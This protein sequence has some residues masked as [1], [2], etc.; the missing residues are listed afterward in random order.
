MYREYIHPPLSFFIP[1]P[2]MWVSFVFST[3]PSFTLMSFVLLRQPQ[4][5]CIRAHIV[6]FISRRQ[7]ETCSSLHG[8]LQQTSPT[9]FSLASH[10]WNHT[11]VILERAFPFFSSFV[12]LD[13]YLKY[14]ILKHH[15][16]SFLK[17]LYLSM[18]HFQVKR[19]SFLPIVVLFKALFSLVQLNLFWSALVSDKS[20]NMTCTQSCFLKLLL[21]SCGFLS[22]SF[23]QSSRKTRVG[24][25][26]IHRARDF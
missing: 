9:P 11:P 4:M 15:C 21:L 8:T 7:R 26:N 17:R 24:S 5:P 3:C 14:C 22:N 25:S 2:L 13:Q 19:F 12:F 23:L 18:S 20:L 16:Q 1:F 10:W 6:Y